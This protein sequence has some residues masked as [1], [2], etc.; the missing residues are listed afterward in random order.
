MN[1]NNNSS[2]SSSSYSSSGDHD[3]F[4]N[5]LLNIMFINQS[6]KE[7]EDFIIQFAIQKHIESTSSGKPSQ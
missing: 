2:N 5:V 4:N 1:L 6:I 7:Q 3:F